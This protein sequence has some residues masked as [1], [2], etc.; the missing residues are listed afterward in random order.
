MRGTDDAPGDAA[1][2]GAMDGGLTA[3]DV[4]E[5]NP[6]GYGR[7][8]R[9]NGHGTSR[10]SLSSY[11]SQTTRGTNPARASMRQGRMTDH[12]AQTA[13]AASGSTATAN[14]DGEDDPNRTLRQG[15]VS[16]FSNMFK[17]ST[18]RDSFS[19]SRRSVRNSDMTGGTVTSSQRGGGGGVGGSIYNASLVSDGR[20][21]SAE[22]LRRELLRQEREGEGKLENVRACCDG[23]FF[24]RPLLPHLPPLTPIHFST[25]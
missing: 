3:D 10:L 16:R 23:M 9:T 15:S 6:G 1:I 5:F 13:A 25:S 18:I 20:V 8:S 14:G 11:N 17:P 2:G 4:D 21:D 24:F 19:M 7:N 22:E 12:S